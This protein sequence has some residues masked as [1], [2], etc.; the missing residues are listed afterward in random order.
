MELLFFFILAALWAG[1]LPRLIVWVIGGVM[2]AVWHG[3]PMAIKVVSYVLSAIIT[4]G[5]DA[6]RAVAKTLHAAS[7]MLLMV[8]FI[9]REFIRPIET[10]PDEQD[11]GPEPPAP[12]EPR[13]L[14]TACRILGLT[15]G[16][17]T[18]DD[19]KR[20][21]R[22]AIRAAHPDLSGNTEDAARINRA[23]D[24]INTHYGWN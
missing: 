5:P 19:L 13:A 20:A 24:D 18:R 16:A 12:H 23:R 21:Y 15:E 10:E 14:E 6:I 22:Q 7:R 9:L 17:F 1:L 4:F 3:V 2:V 11:D 8:Y